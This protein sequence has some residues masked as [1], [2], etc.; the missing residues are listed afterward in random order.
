VLGAQRS[1][2][3]DGEAAMRRAASAR[4][5]NVRGRAAGGVRVSEPAAR[6]QLR[7]ILPAAT[8]RARGLAAVDPRE[9]AGSSLAEEASL[10]QIAPFVGKMKCTMAAA[11]VRAFSEEGDT[12]L[13]PFCGCGVVPLEALILG[14]HAIGNDLNPYAYTIARAKLHAPRTHA[15]ARSAAEQYCAMAEKTADLVDLDEMPGWVRKF[16]HPRTL[17]EAHALVTH[18]RAREEWFLLGCVLG[19]LHHVRPGF[20]SHPAS[21]LTPY[22]REAK[23]PRREFPSMYEYRDVR[24]RLLAK[25]DRIYRRPVV[26]AQ[27]LRSA[28]L[29]EDARDLPLENESIDAIV[30]SPPYFDA[31][32]YGRDNRLRLWFLGV[33][34]YKMLEGALIGRRDSY[35]DDMR[36]SL[37]E[38]HRVLRHGGHCILVLGD[39][40]KNGVV[41]STAEMIAEVARGLE[42][43]FEVEGIVD[44][45]IPDERRSRRRTRTTVRDRVL[46]LRKA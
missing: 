26:I 22:L 19:I 39:V 16:F 42:E 1:T 43:P 44:D 37:C 31:L 35:L 23:Y 4:K 2:I 27:H 11:L 24:S 14:R 6:Y 10:Q 8:I 21:H 5:G 13:D 17:R 20:L 34:N 12:V 9:W 36:G 3:G 28:V 45:I 33:P 30:S 15:L 29:V 40:N 18:L 38:M 7:M 41:K 25:V 32:D 46:V